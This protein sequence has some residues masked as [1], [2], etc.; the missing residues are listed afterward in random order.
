VSARLLLHAK[1]RD[2]ATL[3]AHFYN[4]GYACG[5]PL[6]HSRSKCKLHF[7]GDVTF[8]TRQWVAPLTAVIPVGSCRTG[9]RVHGLEH[10]GR[11]R[12]QNLKGNP[13]VTILSFAPLSLLVWL[14]VQVFVS[15]PMINDGWAMRSQ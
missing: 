6:S 5:L 13:S 12:W 1:S 9:Q 3:S 10:L 7:A 15:L 8:C 14:L 11:K 4:R 2:A